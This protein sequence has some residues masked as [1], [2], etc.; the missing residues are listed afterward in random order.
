MGASGPCLLIES[1]DSMIY[2]T[3]YMYSTAHRQFNA[4]SLETYE[5]WSS[6]RELRGPHTRGWCQHSRVFTRVSVRND[7]ST[8]ASGRFLEGL[9]IGRYKLSIKQRNTFPVA[10]SS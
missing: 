9:S 7:I 5:R 4:R 1:T 3:C 6:L 10:A 8:T 2:K